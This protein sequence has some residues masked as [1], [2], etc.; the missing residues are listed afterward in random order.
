MNRIELY[1]NGQLADLNEDVAIQ[2]DKVVS[3]YR[4]P[5]K[6][7]GTFSLPLVLPYNQKNI[8]IFQGEN[9]K[10]ILGKFRRSYAAQLIVDDQL[11]V[12]GTFL[13]LKNSGKGFEGAVGEARITNPKLGDILQDKKLTDIKSF[14]RLDFSGNQSVMDSWTNTVAFPDSEVCYPTVLNSFYQLKHGQLGISYEDLGISHYVGAVLKNIFA[15]AGYTLAGDILQNGTFRKLVMLYSSSQPQAWNYGKLAPLGADT[16]PLWLGGGYQSSI[17]KRI[18]RQNDYVYVMVYPWTPFEGDLCNSL[19]GDGV[20]TAKFTGMYS[21]RLRA[22]HVISRTNGTVLT[23]PAFTAFRCITDAETIPEDMLPA[24]SSFATPQLEFL[25]MDTLGVGDGTFSFTARLEEGKQY[26]I[27]RYFSVDKATHDAAP[28]F[29]YNPATGGFRISTV[30]GPLLV[31]P[32]LFLPDMNQ[33]EFV[34]AVFKIF[35]L[36]Y[37]LNEEEKTVTLLTRDDFIQESLQEIVDMTPYLDVNQTDDLP[38]TEAEIGQTYL[39]YLPDDN[40]HILK[41]TDYLEKVNGLQPEETTQLPFAPLP[42]VRVTY[43]GQTSGGTTFTGEDLLPAIL[44]AQDS[45]D[46]SVLND[47]D[48][49]TQPGSWVPRL[50]L[51]HGN[52]WLR[53]ELGLGTGFGRFTPASGN[54]MGGYTPG[55]Y[56]FTGLPPKVSF[57]DVNN[58]P[59]YRLTENTTL[60]S[61]DLEEATGATIYSSG[62]DGVI[63]RDVARL[64]ELDT[65]SLAPN[66][67]SSENPKGIFYLLYSNDLLIGNLSNYVQGV[68]RMNPD[69]F[70]HLTGRQLLRLESDL[71]LLESIRNYDLRK[72][73]ATVKLYKFVS[74]DTQ[75]G[76]PSIPVT[77]GGTTTPPPTSG[78][79]GNPPTSGGT[80]NPPTSGGTGDNGG[81]T[82]QTWT[83]TQ[84]AYAYCPDGYI[85]AGTEA[86]A[87]YTSSVSQQDADDVAYQ[88]ALDDATSQLSCIR[89]PDAP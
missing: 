14:T 7:T 80:G 47:I 64:P 26:Q 44:P 52:T 4:D 3:E 53:P 18:D 20:Y 39:S 84:T 42:F 50:L 67:E 24:S 21:F 78:G 54:V 10:Q 77:S 73:Y 63:L 57:F 59:S 19:G 32:A 12:D 65:V 72:E 60:R 25:D 83:S 34:Q 16:P 17:L 85:G 46:L 8:G 31:N 69:L 61:Y 76:L 62:G 58:Q 49:F 45:E 35:N 89:D 74:H 29:T 13:H 48:N 66:V 1:I 37:Q 36:F 2:L 56:E 27:Q 43:S 70:T 41:N 79:T 87:T 55:T 38:L 5:L 68:S 86:T 71:Y 30:D 23:S 28:V 75:T 82:P 33:A 88:M 11:V 81:G 15:D 40:D 6:K 51:Y 22:E 9:D